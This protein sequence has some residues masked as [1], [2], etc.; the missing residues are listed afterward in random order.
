MGLCVGLAFTSV[1]TTARGQPGPVEPTAIS[2]EAPGAVPK[3]AVPSTSP[4]APAAQ[5]PVA[6]NPTAAPQQPAPQQPLPPAIDLHKDAPLPPPVA[7]T[8]HTHDGFY[9]RLSLGFG[10]LGATMNPPQTNGVKGSGSTLAL[11]LALGYAIRPGIILGGTL[12][13]ESLP[14]A[15]LDA[16]TPVVTDI[17]AW[18]L[19]PFFDGYPNARGGFHLGGG[20]GL[21]GCRLNPK[22]AAGFSRSGGFGIAGWLGYD[23]WVAEQ[24]SA[25]IALRLMGTRTKADAIDSFNGAAGKATMATQSIALML[26]GVYN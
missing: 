24:W 15:R 2:N 10:S 18:L 5:P 8:D 6:A 20:L 12:L 7:R 17:S 14:S 13:M 25:G 11:D 4:S 1:G 23:V 26:T 3:I 21:A 16:D 9:A 22:E 19:G